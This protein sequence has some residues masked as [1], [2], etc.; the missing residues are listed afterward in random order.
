MATLCLGPVLTGLGIS[1]K[2]AM[3]CEAGSMVDGR[4]MVMDGR[5]N[6]I[7]GNKAICLYNEGLSISS[8]ARILGGSRQS[9]HDLLIRRDGYNPRKP[10][11]V[12]TQIFNGKKYSIRANGYFMSTKPPR[13]L[14]HRE[15][16][17]SINGTIP[18][19]CD[20]H[21]IDH[22]K[23]NNSIDNLEL[24]TK[25]DHARLFSSGN[26]QYTKRGA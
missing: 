8:I 11:I 14:M 16:W 13:A 21:H 9:I 17:E 26:N 6:D 7:K 24:Y 10:S 22:D 19:G 23:A 20:I 18:D 15:V 5:R 12:K 25:S 1:Y 3:G 2:Q 4:D